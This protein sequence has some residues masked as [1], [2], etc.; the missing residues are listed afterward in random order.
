MNYDQCIGCRYCVTACPYAARTFDFGRV[1]TDGTPDGVPALVGRTKVE[2]YQRAA[3]HEYGQVRERRG[4]ES[5]VGNVR[6]C[7]FC[8]HRLNV[9]MLPACVTTCIGR[10]TFF[11][12]ASDPE[13]LVS[14]LIARPNVMRLKEEL[15]TKPRV[16]YLL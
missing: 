1:Y 12:D 16:Y 4:E 9:G 2:E 8:L 6:K 3:T 10:A 5:P 15:G 11:G 7:H 13:S 14:E